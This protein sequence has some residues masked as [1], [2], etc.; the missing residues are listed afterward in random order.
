ME[1]LKKKKIHDV[2]SV[3]GKNGRRLV[4]WVKVKESMKSR[5]EDS[6]KVCVEWLK[7][8]YGDREVRSWVT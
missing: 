7:I 6:R 8:N 3:M 5:V 1:E 4:S 2:S